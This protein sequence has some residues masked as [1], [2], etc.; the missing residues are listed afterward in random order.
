MRRL[1]TAGLPGQTTKTRAAW[2]D[3]RPAPDGWVLEIPFVDAGGR[4]ARPSNPA[5]AAW[6]AEQGLA[7]SP[8]LGQV[9]L[10]ADALSRLLARLEVVGTP[11]EAYEALDAIDARAAAEDLSGALAAS[12]RIVALAPTWEI[13]RRRRLALLIHGLRNPDAA[14]A[15]LDSLPPGTLP[16]DE[17]R[18]ERQT[19]S[20]LRDDWH[21]Y[22]EQQAA[23]IA[24]GA[25][26]VWS[27]EV[28][29]LA[30]WAAGKLD[31]ALQALSDGLADHPNHRDLELRRAE[32]LG[33]MGRTED[34][35]GHLEML[36][37]EGPPHAKTLAL[38]GWMRR[39]QDPGAAAADYAA[40]L[41]LDP[42]Q[43]VAR[44]GR[45]LQRLDAGDRAGARADLEPFTHCGWTEAADAWARFRASEP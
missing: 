39:A 17:I 10:D 12:E 35:L 19:I 18:R 27:W 15:D 43:P 30:W 14:D 38:R 21:S 25:R 28:L 6:L 31:L 4:D 11:W 16:A 5:Q 3:F 34:A 42:E 44:V 22:A 23:M 41:A 9:A 33:A 2:W 8:S 13:G 36:A 7:V 24:E 1:Q 32:V 37:S 26:Q 20:L 40:A 29:G 45:G